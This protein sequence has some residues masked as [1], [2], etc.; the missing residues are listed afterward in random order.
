[1]Y[2]WGVD[3]LLGRRRSRGLKLRAGATAVAANPRTRPRTTVHLRGLD[4]PEA[5]PSSVGTVPRT[6]LVRAGGLRRC[7]QAPPARGF[8][9]RGSPAYPPEIP[10]A[11][12]LL[13]PCPHHRAGACRREG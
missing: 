8:Q 2:W 7:R 1:M 6:N 5:T 9:P 4:L 12:T 10:S 11:R 3:G 13:P